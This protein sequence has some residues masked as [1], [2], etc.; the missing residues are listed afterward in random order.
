V[1]WWKEMNPNRFR[2]SIGEKKKKKKESFHGGFKAS[3][4][5]EPSSWSQ[6]Q[7]VT[8]LFRDFVYEFVIF[9]VDIEFPI[10]YIDR[11]PI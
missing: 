8:S 4:F 5:S 11:E 3:S 9:P 6:N 1:E 2:F 10:L 7:S